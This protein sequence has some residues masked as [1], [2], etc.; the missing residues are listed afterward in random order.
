MN[1]MPQEAQPSE[2]LNPSREKLVKGTRESDH[3]NQVR[4]ILR[5]FSIRLLPQNKMFNGKDL[6]NIDCNVQVLH[7]FTPILMIAKAKVR[8]QFHDGASGHVKA[9]KPL[10]LI[11]LHAG[12]VHIL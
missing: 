1:I 12:L 5:R 7:R 8:N 2:L 11:L 4:I 10:M 3:S 9:L 6:F